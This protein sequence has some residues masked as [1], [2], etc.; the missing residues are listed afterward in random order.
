[1]IKLISTQ[2]R[3]IGAIAIREINAQ[4]STL[5]YG[6]AWALID[7]GLAVLGLLIM[8]LV[9]R[10]FNPPGLPPATYILSGALVWFMF[11]HMYDLPGQA[12]AKGKRLLSLPL[13]TELD[14]VCAGAIRIFMTYTITLI[15]STT[16]SS[17]FE[18]SPFPRFPLGVMLMVLAACLLGLGLGFVLLLINRAY[19]PAGKFI[20]FPLR[21]GL[22]L[23]GVF[24]PLTKFPSYVWPYLTWNPMLHV[25][26]LLRQYWF[27]AYVSPVGSTLLIA[28]WIVGLLAFGLLCERYSRVRVP[29]R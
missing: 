4:Q 11:A 17:Y 18:D 15:I 20:V 22:F 23:S 19:A 13:I 24:L 14:L 8:K 29:A 26:E 21:F 25:E 28:Q 6:Y 5:M 10:G 27:Y 3:V 7:T 12:I 9:L 2:L 16:I 1:M